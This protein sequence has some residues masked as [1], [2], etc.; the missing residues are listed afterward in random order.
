MRKTAKSLLYKAFFPATDNDFE[1]NKVYII[2][3]GY[4][5]H[6]VVWSRNETFASIWTCYVN[7]EQRHYQS[8]AVVVFDGYPT[9]ADEKDTKTAERHK[10][11]TADVLF[12][13]SMSPT[14]VE[15]KHK[16]ASL[17]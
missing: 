12:D 1:A 17:R 14:V 3:G 11:N 6:R 7:Y 13:E 9:S 10:K 16:L 4:L 8:N 15:R 2:D 5:L